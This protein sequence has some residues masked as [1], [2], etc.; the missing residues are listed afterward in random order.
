MR[1]V[2]YS[3]SE[4]R[5][6][7]YVEMF[8]DSFDDLHIYI[9]DKPYDLHPRQYPQ[10]TNESTEQENQWTSTRQHRRFRVNG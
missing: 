10:P 7:D 8:A 3:Y 1:V 9:D 5:S 4:E 2:I 6:N